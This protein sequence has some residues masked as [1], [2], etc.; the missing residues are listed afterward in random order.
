MV[1]KQIL[2][3]AFTIMAGFPVHAQKP[4]TVP[5]T[6]SWQH[7]RSKI[8][9]PPKLA[10][11]KRVSISD[12]SNSELDVST[13]YEDGA[14][15]ATV[16]LYRPYWNEIGVWF[17]R[18]EQGIL[19]N[20]K[21]G[22]AV[23]LKDSATMFARPGGTVQSGLY[24]LYAIPAGTYRTTA[25]AILPVGNWFLKV[26]YSTPD[27][28]A[29]SVETKLMEVIS[30]IRIPVNASEG[31]PPKTIPLCAIQTKWR[32][33]KLIAP[34][35]MGTMLDGA[36]FMAMMEQ[37]KAK[38]FMLPN[39]CRDGSHSELYTVYRDSSDKEN[40]IMAAGDAGFSVQ[41]LEAKSILSSGKQ[42]WPIAS[43]QAQ[44]ILLPAFNKI[45]SPSTLFAVVAS[46]Q[47]QAVVNDDPDIPAEQKQESMITVSPDAP[48]RER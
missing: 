18:S 25:L 27:T 30:K 2:A 43:T 39:A 48:I 1:K 47:T 20:K 19:A 31:A 37:R 45:P 38:F 36:T 41:V 11:L 46:G 4:I 40:F 42:Y 26:R 6:A 8:I 14:S 3:L 5:E 24:R 22:N 9:L 15:I 10:G 12:G 28:D 16:Y 35:M 23:G 44:H 13:Q 33:A 32:N 7:A 29:T 21:L 34:S 17:D